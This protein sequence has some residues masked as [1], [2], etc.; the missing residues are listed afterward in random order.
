MALDNKQP[1]FELTETDNGDRSPES[2]RLDYEMKPG[3][4][5]DDHDMQRLGKKQQLSRQFHS[6]SIFGLTSVV[7]FTWEA[8][9]A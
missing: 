5:S 8:I 6:I 3:T 7:M 9:L 2:E 4:A 1:I